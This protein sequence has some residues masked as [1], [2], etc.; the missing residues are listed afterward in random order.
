MVLYGLWIKKKNRKNNRF[1]APP[2]LL[3]RVKKLCG[4]LAPED[5]KRL[6]E[7][8]GKNAKVTDVITSEI[9][10]KDNRQN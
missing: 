6:I 8:Y 10:K 1:S 5:L 2:A 7:T 3:G 4:G 9:L